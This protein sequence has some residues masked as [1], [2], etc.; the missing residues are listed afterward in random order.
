MKNPDKY[1]FDKYSF[2]ERS[3]ILIGAKPDIGVSGSI[4][5][6]NLAAPQPDRNMT[7]ADEG[8]VNNVSLDAAAESAKAAVDCKAGDVQRADPLVSA[9]ASDSPSQ[10]L[11]HVFLC[12]RDN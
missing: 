1:S 7:A 12:L 6:V 11:L 5:D 9:F 3:L 4:G 2:S 8:V 10:A